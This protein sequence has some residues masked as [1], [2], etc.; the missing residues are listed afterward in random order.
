MILDDVVGIINKFVPDKNKQEEVKIELEKLEIEKIKAKG[1]ILDKMTKHE[2]L[3]IPSFL[4]ALLGMYVATFCLDFV[5]AILGKEAP[6][7]HLE[8]LAGFCK[9]LVS[10]IF[11]KK[12]IQKFSK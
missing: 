6:I 9:L 3:V 10:L 11:G 12:T 1:S 2:R 8:E 5:F 4:L 7:I